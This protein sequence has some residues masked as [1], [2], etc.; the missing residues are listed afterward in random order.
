MSAFSVVAA[1]GVPTTSS[2]GSGSVM[3][4]LRDHGPDLGTYLVCRS[5]VHLKFIE[6]HCK[7]AG[8]STEF[9]EFRNTSA[10][11]K[12]NVRG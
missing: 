9:K 7:W 10:V 1:L 8:I 2:I 4:N 6:N 3:V 12:M 11:A 5:K